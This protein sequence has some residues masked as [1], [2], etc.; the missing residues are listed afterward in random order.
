MDYEKK[1]KEIV[2]EIRKA[3]LY[4]QANST[5]AVLEEILPELKESEDE[6]IRKEIIKFVHFFYGASLAF[7]H[8][9]SEDD[10]LAWLEKQGNIDKASYEIAEKEKYD[11]VSGQFIECR[12]SF[13][14]FKEDNSYWFE[15]VGN[16]TYIGRS[17][18]IFNKSFHITPRQLYRLFTQQR[19]PKENNE[20]EETNAPTSYGKY[21]DECLSDAAKHFFSEGEDKYSVADLFYAGVKCGRSWLE[22]QGEQKLFDYENANVQQKDFSPK[23][24]M[25]RYSIGDVICDKSCTT[26]NK[27]MQ[28]NIE[29]VDIRNGMYICDK[30]SF[31][32]YWQDEYELVAKKI[33]RKLAKYGEEDEKQGEKKPT[34]NLEPNF[35]FNIGQWIVATG[36]CLYLITKID[37]FN[38]TLVDVDGNEYVFNTS[39]LEDA[40]LWTVQD[41]KD[42]DILYA[43]G[44]YFKE[45]IFMFS[46]FTE[47]NV[48][49]TYFGYDAFDGTFDTDLSR[50][51][52]EEDFVS[53]TLATKEQRD[54][55]FQKMKEAGYKWDA[56]NKE[57]SK[58]EHQG[59]QKPLIEM[60]SPE[61][62]LGISEKE[63]NEVVNDSLYGE[64]KSADKAKP[65][66]HEGD[67]IVWAELSTAKI[68]KIDGDYY[69]VEFIDGTK[70]LPQ[71]DFI[72]RNFCLWTIHAAKDGDVLAS[73]LCDSIILFRGIKDNNI[74]FYCDYDF[75]KIDIPGDRFAINN[76][77]H[78]GNVKD[79]KDFHPATK[80]Q[81]DLLFL[82]MKESGYE[83][84]F[85]KKELKI[86]G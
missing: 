22:K 24:D 62:S 33:E 50:F 2:G 4:A 43:K 5:K 8:T 26:L 29:I 32:I 56:E 83:F 77:Q 57:L 58:I 68:I 18:N 59:E 49:S 20:N 37:G 55:L 39:S 73:E 31:P 13:D 69:E 70:G 64:S 45:Y 48:I 9:V 74:D 1:Y 35:N 53:V 3:Y 82:K 81:R 17:D 38:V 21:V 76:G 23:V 78:Y 41:S 85:E 12:K 75:S 72:D 14:E 54:L 10:M 80:E 11:F 60:K 65:K 7:K 63:Y 84:D 67:W 6:I 34:Y 44:S 28:P 40:H 27:D 15:Y 42:G 66:F 36:K 46:S 51:G 16:D 61:E 30:G 19:C 86:I 79:S 47:D 52:R 71:I 25:P